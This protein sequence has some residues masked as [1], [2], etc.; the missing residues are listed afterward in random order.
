MSDQGAGGPGGGRQTP[1]EC[2]RLA[3]TLRELRA[4]TGLSLAALAARTPYS[5]SSW[6]R[7][8]NGRTLP[9]RQAVERLCA[10]AEADPQRP[11]AL[12]ELAETAWS[13][14]AGREAPP[15]AA[16]RPSPGEVPVPDAGTKPR[17]RHFRLY[18]VL[19]GAVCLLAA[20]T[21]LVLSR[22]GGEPA[23]GD[24]GPA[25]DLSAPLP[26]CH[27]ASCTGRHPE[28]LECSTSAQPPI[29]LGE[30]RLDGTVVKVRLSDVC[31]AVWARIDRGT[32]GD[33]VEIVVPGTRVQ[34]VTVKDRFDEMGSVSTPMAALSDD[35]A[36][37][38][39]RACLV[40]QGERHCFTA[41]SG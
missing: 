24:R 10:L 6:E 5:K 29:T 12:W 32:A 31:R 4:A 3:G 11:L 19:L 7:Y 28:D 37:S 26:G 16:K 34:G 41:T 14:R 33:R 22:P 2:A 17:S 39:V 9:P 23:A 18:A 38:R 15:S 40:R 1:P 8:L 35:A 25:A 36:L 13:G 20:G 30:Q 27:G 21:L